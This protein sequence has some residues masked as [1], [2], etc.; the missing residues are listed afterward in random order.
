MGVL[1]DSKLNVSQHCGLRAKVDN[2]ILGCV[3]KS[4]VCRFVKVVFPLY[5]VLV[6]PHLEYC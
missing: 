2:F 1:R 4:V 6:R 5:L 3:S